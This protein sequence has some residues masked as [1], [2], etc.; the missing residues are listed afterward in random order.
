MTGQPPELCPAM[1]SG[2]SADLVMPSSLWFSA[3]SMRSLKLLA[4]GVA[5][6]TKNAL[7]A[8][9]LFLV[10]SMASV[11]LSHPA[12]RRGA[13]GRQIT[14]SARCGVFVDGEIELDLHVSDAGEQRLCEGHVA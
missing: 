5:F 13:D 14:K 7:S 8:V 3:P 12:R 10:I 2:L 4:V 9:R 1:D 11:C 6:L